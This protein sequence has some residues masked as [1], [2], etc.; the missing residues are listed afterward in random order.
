MLSSHFESAARRSTQETRNCCLLSDSIVVRRSPSSS[1]R[2]REVFSF[3]WSRLCS[4]AFRSLLIVGP[5]HSFELGKSSSPF[6]AP[7]HVPHSLV[8]LSVDVTMDRQGVLDR[9][10]VSSFPEKDKRIVSYFV[11]TDGPVTATSS[12]ASSLSSS[13]VFSS[14]SLLSSSF[15]SL[16][17]EGWTVRVH[18]EERRADA[19]E[20]LSLSCQP[21][22]ICRCTQHRPSRS[23]TAEIVVI[24]VSL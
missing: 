12:H 15:S 10:C 6:F 20:G 18:K 16:H 9:S 8:L 17:A 24:C 2:K 23:R 4:S 3:G 22:V 21:Q 7:R 14:P 13:S 11:P 1:Q 5:F 19:S